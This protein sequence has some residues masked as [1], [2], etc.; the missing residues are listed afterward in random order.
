MTVRVEGYSITASLEP[1][2]PRSTISDP[3]FDAREL[4]TGARVALKVLHLGF[5][6]RASTSE[7]FLEL[8]NRARKIDSPFAVKCLASGFTEDDHA[9]WFTMQPVGAPSLASAIHR[10]A[11]CTPAQTRKILT[12][13]VHASTAAYAQGLEESLSLRHLSITSEGEARCWN[14]GVG[15]W[16]VA[17]Q[18]VVAGTYTAA[19]QIR[20]G[21]EITP[22]ALN[23][24]APTRADA[25]VSLA[26]ISFA[27][28]SGRH[29]WN[30]D[31]SPDAAAME[32]MMEV[33]AGPHEAPS[34]RAGEVTLPNGYDEWFSVCVNGD[35]ADAPTAI[36]QLP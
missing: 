13:A 17:S 6:L 28:L 3:V 16:R 11:R 35:F 5:P 2:H 31:Q 21:T 12:E 9:P 20:W 4:A 18:A 10:G 36:G 14:F 19:G 32:L 7:N 26:L 29:Y 30:A 15:A 22:D 25:V 27:L 33:M 24:K 34:V 23:G 8:I 1:P